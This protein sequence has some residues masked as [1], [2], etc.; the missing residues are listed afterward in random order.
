MHDILN[1]CVIKTLNVKLS[2]EV[3]QIIISYLKFNV[4]ILIYITLRFVHMVHRLI[5][6]R[7]FGISPL[8]YLMVATEILG[9][10]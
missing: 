8:A 2:F 10:M 5:R 1:D 9:Q 4:I 3:D 6:H 7:P